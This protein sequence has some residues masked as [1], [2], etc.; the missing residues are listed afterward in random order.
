MARQ[1]ISEL[2][3]QDIVGFRLRTDSM[4][5]ELYDRFVTLLERKGAVFNGTSDDSSAI[6]EALNSYPYT[7]ARSSIT[8]PSGLK[9]K[10]NSGITIPIDRVKVDF[11]NSLIDASGLTSGTAVLLSSSTVG[12]RSQQV[13]GVRNLNLVGPSRSGS[14]VALALLGTATDTSARCALYNIH[15]EEFGVAYEFRDHAYLVHV[16]APSI[17]RCGKAVH[18]VGSDVGENISFHGGVISNCFLHAHL[19]AT[20]SELYHFGT[21]IDYCRQILV[22]SAASQSRMQLYGCHVESRGADSGDAFHIL[23]GSGTDNRAAVATKDSHF[24]LD[25]DGTYFAMHGGTLDVNGSGGAGPYTYAQLVNVRH[26]NARATFRDVTFRNT[27]NVSRKFWTGQGLVVVSDSNMQASPGV[28]V[29]ISDQAMGNALFDGG[30][31]S[32]FPSDFWSITRD[33]ATISSRVTGSNISISRQTAQHNSGAS[34]LRV[35]KAGAAATVARCGVF[36]PVRAGEKISARGFIYRDTMN[37]G[38]LFAAL[39][40]VNMTGVDGNGIPVLGGAVANRL[41]LAISANIAAATLTTNIA[42]WTEFAIKTFDAGSTTDA[43]APSWATHV[44]LEF[45]L[46]NGNAG[47][48]Y[49]DDLSVS[50]W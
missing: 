37:T 22:A 7:G 42:A 26:K 43:C 6:Q 41:G 46:D 11:S 10:I 39:N 31:E 18:I 36:V 23:D 19:E 47:D 49:F 16:F 25:G 33:T 44:M 2:P 38:A 1:P 21:S 48:V 35:T 24:D 13:D 17:A 5:A 20:T 14:V 29:R 34:A 12:L 27:E 3:S 40:W 9:G 8:F 50:R 15:M 4:F 30:F 45:L 28:S 32:T